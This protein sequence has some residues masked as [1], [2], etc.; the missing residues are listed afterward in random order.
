[1]E[2]YRPVLYSIVTDWMPKSMCFTVGTLLQ[3]LKRAPSLSCLPGQQA[4]LN[5]S[6]SPCLM[7][8][9]AT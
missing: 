7:V 1:M 5:N 6:G 4:Q 9:N 2:D 8:T 3:F